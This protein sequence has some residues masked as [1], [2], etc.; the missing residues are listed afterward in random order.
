MMN[1]YRSSEVDVNLYLI[2]NVALYKEDPTLLSEGTEPGIALGSSFPPLELESAGYE[3]C[4]IVDRSLFYVR[5]DDP[6]LT[7]AHEIGHLMVGAGHPGS[8]SVEHPEDGGLAALQNLE[9]EEHKK[10]LMYGS[11]LSSRKLL[12]KTE[13]D[14][15]EDWLSTRSNGDN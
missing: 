6:E 9:P 11:N 5:N 7:A 12:V 13:W 3:N 1:S 4:V 8:Y 2:D 15:A 14:L 10:R